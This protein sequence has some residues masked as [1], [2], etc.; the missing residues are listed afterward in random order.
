M[1]L[2]N[3]DDRWGAVSQGFHWLIVILIVVMA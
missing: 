2:H 3:S 1:S